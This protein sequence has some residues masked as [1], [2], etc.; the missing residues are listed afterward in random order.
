MFRRYIAGLLLLGSCMMAYAQQPAK[1]SIKS[2]IA[3]IAQKGQPI[4]LSRLVPSF[5]N[6]VLIPAQIKNKLG[7]GFTIFDV[8]L[9][10]EE[11]VPP[12]QVLRAAGW[13]ELKA[14]AG[15]AG[16]MT[17]ADLKI[18][19]QFRVYENKFGVRQFVLT[20]FFPTNIK[21]SQIDSQ[22]KPLD[23]F[24]L[25]DIRFV[26][27]TT[28]HKSADGVM[29]AHGLN[30][31][32]LV[33]LKGPLALLGEL[34]NKAK[35]LD[36][37]IVDFAAPVQLSGSMPTIPK[38]FT[39]GVIV[40]MRFGVD[41]QKIAGIPQGFTDIIKKITTDDFYLSVT[42]G[43]R[44]PSV[45]VFV[46]NGMQVTIGKNPEPYILQ[47]FGNY[48]LVTQDISFGGK[49]PS[50]I[51]FDY[52]AVGDAGI[53][54][55]MDSGARELLSAIGLPFTGI[56]L[57]GT[58]QLGKTTD[59]R[60]ELRLATKVAFAV[61][62]KPKPPRPD[63]ESEGILDI[64][65]DVTLSPLVIAFDVAGKHIYISDLINM[66]TANLVKAKILKPVPANIMPP[67]EFYKVRGKYAPT[68]VSV[69]GREIG[70]G[71][72][73]ELDANLFDRRFN[74]FID[75]NPK[76]GKLKGK[77]WTEP[78]IL[79]DGNKTIFSL[80]GSG[81]DQKFDTKDDGPYV[82]CFFDPSSITKTAFN[83]STLL[84]I[85]PLALKN[86]VEFHYAFGKFIAEFIAKI[87]KL[88]VRFN[89]NLDMFKWREMQID[90]SITNG[91]TDYLSQHLKKALQEIQAGSSQAGMQADKAFDS[92]AQDIKQA[93]RAAV[94]DTQKEIIKT[95][96][97]IA[98]IKKKVAALEKE[99]AREK[100]PIAKAAICT[101][102][103]IE[104]AAQKT[105]QQAQ[106]TYLYGL[107][108][109]GK[110]IIQA[111]TDVAAKTTKEV[112]KSGF[113]SGVLAGLTQVAIAGIK[114]IDS[115]INIFKVTK[116]K[117]KVRS[118][119]LLAGKLPIIDEFE[120]VINVPGTKPID[121]KLQGLT[122]DFN[123]PAKSA[124][125]IMKKIV[126]AIKF[127]K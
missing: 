17:F 98:T 28:K 52:F 53:E 84:E 117:G 120:A 26:F 97:T 115:G 64:L 106:E 30:L 67:I 95:K 55:F 11:K 88:D 94:S 2:E 89:V 61:P 8:T 22:L 126:Q 46:Q 63:D 32:S 70:A 50:M 77:G 86:K 69:A 62:G 39:F 82:T 75:I 43:I 13:N 101:K 71:F 116:A 127:R 51:D 68:G 107:L 14:V 29:V 37:I 27:A 74:F 109:P 58:I 7:K 96:Q 18:K 60:A 24:T 65:D 54:L 4:T 110:D 56:G 72:L 114:A 40:P 100:N 79:K 6:D 42:Y 83:I 118:L 104:I 47:G 36:S 108:K 19:T 73:L 80:T 81:K 20:L 125:D 113:T 123:N 34:R 48:N 35:G 49:F 57:R 85:P 3:A 59:K 1:Q 10:D 90:Y 78:I 87:H 93:Q 112:G 5:E 44:K 122:F 121:I 76:K 105:A 102:V 92:G 66:I 124:Q 23:I 103:G 33:D 99:C 119:D 25:P 41:F 31:I 21:P 91:L 45:H 12:I 111:T 38:S 16:F 15:F 9:D